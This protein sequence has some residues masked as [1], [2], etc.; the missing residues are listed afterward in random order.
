MRHTDDLRRGLKERGIKYRT[1][2]TSGL[3]VERIQETMW[4]AQPGGPCHKFTEYSNN[5]TRLSVVNPTAAQA[6]AATIGA[7]G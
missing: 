7:V 1:Y 6:I 3:A 2:D 4:E 5:Q